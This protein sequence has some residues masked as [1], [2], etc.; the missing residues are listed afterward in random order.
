MINNT[1]FIV[2]EGYKSI[3]VALVVT[4]IL[5]ILGCDFLG[6]IGVILTLLIVYIYRDTARYIYENSSNILSPIDGKVIAIDHKKHSCKIYVQVCLLNSHNIL[7]PFNT[8]AKVKLKQYGTNLDPSS[9]KGSLLNEQIKIKFASTDFED[10]SI[11]LRLISGF[12]NP[13][14]SI[15]IKENYQQGEKI[16]VFVNGIAEITLKDLEPSVAINDRIKAGQTIISQFN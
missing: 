12:F 5:Y 9:Y 15:N 11:K 1:N 10:K 6:A 4:F 8:T 14:I 2:K 3:F 16:G 13:S 7:S